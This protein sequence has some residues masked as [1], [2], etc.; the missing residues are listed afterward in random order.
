V[1]RDLLH[2]ADGL[3]HLN[4][5]ADCCVLTLAISAI[6]LTLP[7]CTTPHGQ[8]GRLG[9]LAA[10]FDLLRR[11]FDQ[12]LDLLGGGR[13]RCANTRTSLATTPKPRPARLHGRPPRPH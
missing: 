10:L 8:A 6:R 9:T 2:G 7:T 11:R 1:L 13:G 4:H 12:G 3:G 5:A